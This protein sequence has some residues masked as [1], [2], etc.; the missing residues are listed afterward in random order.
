MS[1]ISI[2]FEY[3]EVSTKL[4]EHNQTTRLYDTTKVKLRVCFTG[5]MMSVI[6]KKNICLLFA[7]T[8]KSTKLLNILEKNFQKFFGKK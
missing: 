2:V 3:I 8:K 6:K 5:D 7:V 1:F 4:A